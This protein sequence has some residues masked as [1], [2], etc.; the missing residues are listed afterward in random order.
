MDEKVKVLHSEIRVVKT[1]R[2]DILVEAEG[3]IIQLEI[4][5]QKDKTLPRRMFRY[6]YAI[7]EK[8]KKKEP[9]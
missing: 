8:Y 5:A 1:F 9:T 3:K 7:E 4:Q 6:Y 2:P